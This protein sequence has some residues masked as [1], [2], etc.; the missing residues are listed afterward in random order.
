MFFNWKHK[1]S[2]SNIVS[3][4]L[5]FTIQ[6]KG[7]LD[8]GPFVRIESDYIRTKI[9]EFDEMNSIE[10]TNFYDITI[11]FDEV[12]TIISNVDILIE[13]ILDINGLIV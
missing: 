12:A 5:E 3:A 11:G 6:E 2:E 9:I 10:L 1:S 7:L 4:Y 13:P 8:Q